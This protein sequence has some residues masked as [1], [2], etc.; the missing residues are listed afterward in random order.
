MSMSVRLPM[1]LLLLTMAAGIAHAQTPPDSQPAP[2]AAPSRPVMT[3]EWM[4]E[5]PVEKCGT[6]CREWISAKGLIDANSARTFAEFTRERST[7]GATMVIE[8]EGGSVSA[9]M[10]LGRLLRQLNI[11]TTI[12]RTEKLGPD[13]TGVE[14]ATFSPAAI[15]ASMCPFVVLGGARRSIPPEARVMVHQ[16]WP[17][18]RREDAMAATYTA[19]DF[20][21][22]QRELGLLAKYVVEMGGDM[23]LYE[24]ALRIPPWEAMRPLS[25]EELRRLKLNNSED[26]FAPV[27]TA[28]VSAGAATIAVPARR[29]PETPDRGWTVSEGTRGMSRKHPLT[30][31]GVLIGSFELSFTC[32]EQGVIATY[33]EQRQAQDDMHGDHLALVSVVSGK[34]AMLRMTVRASSPEGRDTLR[35]TATAKVPAEFIEALAAS[36]GRS[37]AIGTLTMRRT[38]TIIQ[39]GNTGFADSFKR[40]LANC[41]KQ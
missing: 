24:I 28:A 12:G 25:A 27:M 14:R 35:S 34:K 10:T 29:V 23:E 6:H 16:I 20:V 2:Q 13:A 31:E 15:C 4:R 40:T 41:A 5:G 11:S 39:P 18:L 21:G 36:E 26:A 9:A 3:F 38:R 37:L 1:V 30:L 33:V 17:R 22:L 8:S 7:Q 19:Q 32:G